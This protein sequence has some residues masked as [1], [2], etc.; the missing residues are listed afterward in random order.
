M[1]FQELTLLQLS[2][3]DPGGGSAGNRRFFF[4][5]ELERCVLSDTET[6]TEHK[7]LNEN[8]E[9]RKWKFPIKQSERKGFL[10]FLHTPHVFFNCGEQTCG[11]TKLT[12]HSDKSYKHK[13][14]L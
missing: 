5:L 4:G 11:I 6:E 10:V 13:Q 12:S 2:S 3:G 1:I 9:S 14:S 8:Q 7:S